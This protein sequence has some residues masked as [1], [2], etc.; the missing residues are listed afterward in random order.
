[1]KIDKEAERLPCFF[2]YPQVRYF[3]TIN[4]NMNLHD[5]SQ[6]MSVVGSVPTRN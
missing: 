3:K 4:I 1:M 6:L 2:T 5:T